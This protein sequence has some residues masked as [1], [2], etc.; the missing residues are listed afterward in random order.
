MMLAIEGLRIC[1]ARIARSM[2]TLRNKR[3]IAHKNQID[4]N[5]FDLAFLHQSAAWIVAEFIRTASGITMQE[6][7]KLVEQV[8]APVRHLVEDI[9]GLRLV[10]ASVPI[11]AEVLI[12]LHSHFPA[13]V[14]VADITSSLKARNSGA[15]RNKLREMCLNK[16]L[17]GD[18]NTGYRLTQAG[19]ATAVE[20]IKRLL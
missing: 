15:V 19:H 4:P 13:Y 6:A 10:H 2:Y 14:A 3:N 8:Q 18:P 9:D 16:L 7:G 1:A 11:G 5:T 20:E 12:L 17:H